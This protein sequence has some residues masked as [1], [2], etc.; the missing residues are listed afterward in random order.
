M[1]AIL[2]AI[3]RGALIKN[4]RKTVI[5]CTS[6]SP[7]IRGWRRGDVIPLNRYTENHTAKSLVFSDKLVYTVLI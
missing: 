4:V 3:F 7:P 6:Q 5:A 1:T 2:K